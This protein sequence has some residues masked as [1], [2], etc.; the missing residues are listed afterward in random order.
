M[1]KISYVI[2][3]YRSAHTLEA[4]VAEITATMAGL[5]RY[6]YEV[7][8]VND[9][10]PDD[11]IGTI[12]RLVAADPHVQGVDLAKNFGQHAAL[13]AGF[14]QCSGDI[15]V[16]LDDDGQTP[17]DEVGKLLDKIEAGYDVVYA[18]Y[19]TKRQAGWRNLGSWVN[20]KMTEIMLGKAPDLVVN[21]Y[22]AAR[23]FV[24]EEMIRYEHCY[25][26]VIGLVLRTTKNICNVPVHHRQREE[27]RS[28]YTL[29]KL[30]GLWMNGFTSF[31]VKP[32]RI[33]TYF[34]TLSALA[35]FLYL[36]FI[37]IN[38]F[39]RH[40]APL[41]WASTTALLLLLGGVILIVL[42]LIGEYVG[43]IYMCANAAPQYVA[44]EY[45]HHEE[46]K[47]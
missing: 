24:V 17:A 10:S 5:A 41:G 47:R 4:V 2:P 6:D 9:C 32:L 44:R 40:T 37:V 22:F 20:S 7:V 35:G 18:R 3:C 1:Q 11:T 39:T 8:L 12:R 31:S 19:D 15:I 26:Y 27:G 25:P 30:L 21:S 38:H 28:G 33:A 45:L 43:R 46:E 29:R 34:G 14:H 16:C 36:I 13:M 23:R 42:G